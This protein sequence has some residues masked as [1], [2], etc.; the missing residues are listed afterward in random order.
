MNFCEIIKFFMR[1]LKNMWL[2]EAKLVYKFH[3]PKA[4]VIW[5]VHILSCSLTA[6]TLNW[7]L[8]VEILTRTLFQVKTYL[9]K[10]YRVQ[11]S[12]LHSSS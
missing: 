9:L 12:L 3:L 6:G 7:E 2:S 10:A 1:V 11:R 8:W 4:S 5:F